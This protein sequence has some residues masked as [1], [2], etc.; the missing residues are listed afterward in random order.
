[1]QSA[2]RTKPARWALF[3]LL[4]VTYAFAVTSLGKSAGVFFD[5]QQYVSYGRNWLATGVYGDTPGVPDMNRE[6]GYGTFLAGVF[7]LVKQTGLVG[8]L[9]AIAEPGNIFWARLAQA[10]LLFSCAGF[11]AFGGGLP[12]RLRRPFFL[13]AILSPTLVGA[14]REIYSEALAI[15]LSFLLLGCVSR[16]LA[17]G[18]KGAGAGVAIAQALL[19]LT[20]S[21]LYPLSLALLPFTA[22]AAWRR[23]YRFA[24]LVALPLALGGITAQKAW[25]ARNRALFG[26]GGNE[27][28]KSIA[29]AGKIARIDHASW[30]QD[31]PVALA[32][33]VG[34]NFCDARFGAERCQFFDYRGC[35]VIGNEILN[36]YRARYGNGRETDRK[37]QGDMIA[38]A[39]RRPFSQI[40]GSLLELFRMALFEA[41]QDATSLPKALQNA[42]RAWHVVGSFGGWVLILVSCATFWRRRRGWEPGE[43]PLFAFCAILVLYHAVTMSQ[44]TNVVRYVFP[45]LP[46][47]YYFVADGISVTLERISA[48][49][50][51]RT[52]P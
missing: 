4:G 40:T 51:A 5:S 39:L 18:S 50:A 17:R 26:D 44:I 30:R 48:W 10:F 31:L 37:I 6:P 8:D 49:R 11:C 12:A 25:D 16:A 41:V 19:V 42:A 9:A 22:V 36:D 52:T 3:L 32:A 1:M 14:A 24:W 45:I 23:Q 43:A 2:I 13:L 35:D 38:L 28:R 21:Y 7:F 20:K 47:L 34:T 29:I 46:F 33:S 15:P 27:A